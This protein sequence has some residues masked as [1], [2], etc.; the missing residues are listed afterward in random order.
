MYH[1]PQCQRGKSA[2]VLVPLIDIGLSTA[3][4]SFVKT[5]VMDDCRRLLLVIAEALRSTFFEQ[6]N[7]CNEAEQ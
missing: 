5:L 1:I 7:T 2:V 6:R 4:A 3:Q